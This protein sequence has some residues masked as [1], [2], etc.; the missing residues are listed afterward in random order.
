MQRHAGASAANRPGGHA[1]RG[2]GDRDRGIRRGIESAISVKKNA[3]NIVEAISA[4]DIGKL[5]DNSIAESIARLPGVAAQR[6]AGRAQVISVRGPSPDFATTLLNGR[7]MVSTGDN[8]SVEFDQYPSELVSGVT[9]Y[10]TPDAALIGQGLSG[11]LDMQ[12]IRP[13]NFSSRQ[14]A[15]NARYTRNLLGSAANAKADGNRFSVSYI[16][17]FADRT[18]G[19]VI[20]YAHQETPVQE[21]Q[22]GLYEP[23]KQVD[24]NNTNR[25]GLANGTYVSDGIE[26]LRRTGKTTRDGIMATVE[27]K[28]FKDWTSTLDL[29]TSRTKQEDTANQFEV[30]LQYNGN[31]PCNP[32]CTFSAPVV[33]S[34]SSLTSADITG[35][36]PLVRGMYNKRDDKIDA[37]GWNNRFKVGGV[38]L[39]ADASYSKAKRDEL[40]LEN[41]SQL[42]L[43]P[44]YDNLALRF[45][46]DDFST[47][48]P[49]LNYSD[50]SRLF[51][52]DTIYGSGYGKVPSVKDELAGF[53]LGAVVPMPDTVSSFMADVNVGINYA[54]RSKTKRQPEG[55][56]NVGAQG[57]TAIASDLQYGLVNLGFAGL[58]NIPSW[59]VPGAVARYM[60]FAPSD[61]ANYLIAKAWEVNEKITTA[62]AKANIDTQLGS[63]PVR[64]DFGL[65]VQS[66]DQSSNSRY[67]DGSAPAGQRVK[68]LSGGKTYTDVL[69]SLN[70]SF[71]LGNDQT[72]RFAAAKQVARPKVDQLRAGIDFGIDEPSGKPGASGGN[73][74]VDPWRADAFD[75]SYEK[76]FGNKAYLA[77]AA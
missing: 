43:S 70:L 1:G 17:Q 6:V 74:E 14:I 58:G 37:F 32:A 41:N 10:K 46:T 21:N 27:F 4:E 62:Y 7:E 30:N 28:P 36:Y 57:P 12:T 15:L 34:N 26:A 53:R 42:V 18:I 69:P 73:P 31:F 45:R 5:P 60:V 55:N 23:W 63:V 8:R 16:D 47:I 29:F 56:I 68:P 48:N 76:Y 75:V 33:S 39:V 65:Q 61:T 20:G 24:G 9:I 35:V 13:L 50:S 11:T 19:L 67:F 64:G 54:D 49:G 59:N 72:L 71:D 52:R 3:G 51:L 38:A 2:D 22:V 77:A 25:P 40:S 66:V 44:Q